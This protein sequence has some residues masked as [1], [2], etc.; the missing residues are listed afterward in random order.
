MAKRVNRAIPYGQIEK[1]VKA[2]ASCEQIAKAINRYKP[3]SDDPTKSVRA[4]LSLMRTRGWRD[5][6]GKLHKLQRRKAVKRVEAEKR[7]Q[8]EAAKAEQ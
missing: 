1:M 7:V 6:G 5:Q 8:P 2:G 4:I 3:K